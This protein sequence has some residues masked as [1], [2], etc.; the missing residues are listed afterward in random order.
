MKSRLPDQST[1]KKNDQTKNLEPLAQLSVASET[2]EPLRH[3]TGDRSVGYP[4]ILSVEP[5]VVRLLPRGHGD[6][7]LKRCTRAISRIKKMVEDTCN[8][9][10]V[11]VVE[12]GR[13]ENAELLEQRFDYIFFTGSVNVGKIVMEKASRYLTPV[14]L[15]LGGKSPCIVDDA[16]SLKLAAKRI[17]FGKFLNAG[18]TCVAPDYLL[19]RENLKDRFLFYL[20]NVIHEFFGENPVQNEQL[21]KIINEKHFRRLSE[22]LKDQAVVIG[23]ECDPQ[24]LKIAPTVVDHVNGKNPLMQEE[25]F[26]P[27]LP[28]LTY[29]NVDDAI[30]FIRGRKA[31]GIISLFAEEGAEEVP[32][33]IRKFAERRM[34]S[35]LI[36]HL[37]TSELGFGRLKQRHGFLSWEEKFPDIFP[38]HRWLAKSV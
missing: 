24:T 18:Q 16:R 34:L 32:E 31:A 2:Y 8:K 4:F 9:R 21:V 30:R 38:P 35:M 7:Q 17:A 11:A 19:I 27:I 15:E 26:G 37:A 3:D 20:R 29:R 14:T 10:Y 23:G 13:K 1:P 36:I 6:H 33:E 22:L 28:V 12:G 5:A 25:I